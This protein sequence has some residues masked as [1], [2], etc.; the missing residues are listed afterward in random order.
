MCQRNEHSGQALSDEIVREV[1]FRVQRYS[2]GQDRPVTREYRVPVTRGMTVLDG[3]HYIRDNL[4]ATLSYRFSCRMGVCGSCG[5]YIN[6]FPRLAC[7]TQILEL[8]SDLVDVR[9][10][11]NYPVVKDLVPDLSQLFAKHREVQPFIIRNEQELEHPTAEFLQKPEEL[12]RYLQFTYCIK[13]GLCLT[14]CPTVATDPRYLGPQALAQSYRYCADTRDAGAEG[15]LR[16]AAGRDG[17]WRC[18]LAGACSEACPKGVDPALG[19]Q[20]LKRLAVL[21]ALSLKKPH[22]PAPVAGK[23]TGVE[24]RPGIPQP[25]PPT[26][27]SR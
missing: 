10:M 20:L 19:I 26:V 18:H 11:P 13:C 4:D 24:R 3:L 22:S 14:A 6:S 12:L 8:N 2:P 16:I 27:E 5:M 17:V 23:R 21:R 1:V 7:Q 25:P 15:R 9:P